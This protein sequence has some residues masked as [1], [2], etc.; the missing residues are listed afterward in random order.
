MGKSLAP[1]AS[2]T[3]A[4]LHYDWSLYCTPGLYDKQ[5]KYDKEYKSSLCQLESGVK[6]H[7]GDCEN[8]AVAEPLA[9]A[10]GTA[11]S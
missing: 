7:V 11:S 4:E 3:S 1:W 9:G 6:P 10:A 2:A 8:R 5:Y